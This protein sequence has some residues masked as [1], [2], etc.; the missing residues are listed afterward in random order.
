MRLPNDSLLQLNTSCHREVVA[1]GIG[2]RAQ[3]GTCTGR[4]FA[5]F[6]P[7][8]SR[9]VFNTWKGRKTQDCNCC[10]RPAN[11]STAIPDATAK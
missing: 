11:A 5:L 1:I 8:P 2:R 9:E 3:K 6:S 7:S 10:F 4:Q